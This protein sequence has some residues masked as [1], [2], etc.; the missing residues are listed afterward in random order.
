MP[1][2]EGPLVG[3]DEFVLRAPVSQ[4]RKEL[5]RL[6]PAGLVPHKAVPAPRKNEW[7]RLPTVADYCRQTVDVDLADLVQALKERG[8]SRETTVVLTGSYR[9]MREAQAN[10]RVDLM[11]WKSWESWQG[12]RKTRP[13]F[14]P[15]AIPGGF[16]DE[17]CSYARGANFFY[18]G[19][20]AAAR[21]EWAKILKLDKAQRKY[22]ST[23]AAFMI[24]RTLV[25][26]DPA[27]AIGLLRQVRALAKEGFAD[28][29]G[30]AA[31]S[32]GWEARALLNMNMKPPKIAEAIDLYLAQDAAGDPTAM[33]S[34]Q[35]AAALALKQPPKELADLAANPAT[36]RVITAFIVSQ[37]GPWMELPEAGTMKPW[38]SAVESAKVAEADDAERFAQ[39][40]Y[41]MGDTAAAGRWLKLAPPDAVMTRWIHAKLLLRDGKVREAREELA[42]IS[43]RIPKVTAET[44]T[45][46]GWYESPPVMTERPPEEAVRFEL[47]SIDLSR[48]RYQ[49]SLDALIAGGDWYDT[50][51]IAERVLTV[52]ELKAYVD[53]ACPPRVGGDPKNDPLWHRVKLR[54]L[55]AR[56]LARL[57]RLDEAKAYYP[58]EIL[59]RF[60]AYAKGVRAG[61][62]PRPVKEDRAAALWIAA[63]TAR[64]WGMELLGTELDPDY[65]VYHGG[66]GDDGET[67]AQPAAAKPK[68]VPPSAD[69]KSRVKSSRTEP[70]K[71][72]HYRYLAADLAWK[73]AELMPDQSDET[74]RVLCEA[75]TWLKARD[76]KAADRFY[77]ALVRRC[78]KTAL[79]R[80]ADALRWFPQ[81][82]DPAPAGK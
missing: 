4:F 43:G 25:E 30:L 24:G 7:D 38:L 11:E 16:P 58:A 73:A 27:K 82:P 59:P 28:S 10:Y 52:D 6:R 51:Y 67:E 61:N 42:F 65:A 68:L 69:E 81:L 78:G 48:G 39:A 8:T 21:L 66:A 36:R 35:R 80:E 34:L 62:D 41:Q 5:E 22:R 18:A 54:L 50:A 56:R 3:D 20:P 75:G 64:A 9:A 17:F 15:P 32:Y 13:E 71:R 60:E 49:D 55:L 63:R 31:A 79:G 46:D 33:P 26:S 57:G 40:A 2:W 44:D 76:P 77:K 12:E 72:F 23:W 53:R 37:G 14:A 45:C 47:G 74:A 1:G 19:D 70:H 29:L